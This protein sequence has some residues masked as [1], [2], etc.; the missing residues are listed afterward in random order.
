LSNQGQ[1]FPLPTSL[2]LSEQLLKY[3]A[4][5]KEE[6][7]GGKTEDTYEVLERQRATTEA[8]VANSGSLLTFQPAVELLANFIMVLNAVV[9]P[10]SK[11][12]DPHP[13]ITVCMMGIFYKCISPQVQHWQMQLTS[14]HPHLPIYL[15]NVAEK[16]YTLGT[17]TENLSSNL[18]LVHVG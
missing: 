14:E 6:E 8:L 1:G 15:Y 11:Y 12:G 10:G 2:L 13:V 4:L 9:V 5:K 3:V 18:Q 16:V 7:A 17:T